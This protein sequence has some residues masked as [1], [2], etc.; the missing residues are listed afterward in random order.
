MDPWTRFKEA[1]VVAIHNPNHEAGIAEAKLALTLVDGLE[2]PEPFHEILPVEV[3]E[4]QTRLHVAESKRLK[5]EAGQDAAER[6]GRD[7]LES[8]AFAKR[9]ASAAK[10]ELK[11]RSEMFGTMRNEHVATTE[12]AIDKCL[13]EHRILKDQRDRAIRNKSQARDWMGFFIVLGLITVIVFGCALY[14][15]CNG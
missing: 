4:L 13:A 6:E 9:E 5:A 15:M 3:E 2:V 12:K 14:S 11:M 7:T 8:L 10:A 1:I